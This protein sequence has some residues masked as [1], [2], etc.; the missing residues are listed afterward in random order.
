[1]LRLYTFD[2]SHFSEKARWALDYEGLDYE[3]KVL[4]PGPHQLV[5]RRIARKTSVPVLEHDGH[6]VQGSSAIL[7]YLERGLGAAKLA[8]KSDAALADAQSLEQ[9]VDRAFGLGAQRVLYSALLRDRKAV[10]ALW[11][12]NGPTWARWFYALAYPGVAAVVARMYRTKDEAAVEQ[13]KRDFVA[14]FDELDARLERQPY[15]GGDAP[16]RADISVASLFAPV[17]R[18]E[19]HRVKWPEVPEALQPFVATLSG[20]PTWQH[21][22][23]MYREHRHGA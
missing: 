19:Q 9:R 16:G 23:R 1:M 4:V 11:T 3:E 8:P 21:T 5:T 12:A 22:L 13:S 6:V 18:P 7:D 10:T 14:M 20:R 15:L 17:C 2:I